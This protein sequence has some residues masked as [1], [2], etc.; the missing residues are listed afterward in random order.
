MAAFRK[1]CHNGLSRLLVASR[2]ARFCQICLSQLFVTRV[3]LSCHPC[4]SQAVSHLLVRSV[5]RKIFHIRLPP[6]LCRLRLLA[7]RHF[8]LSQ[9]MSGLSVIVS[10]AYANQTYSAY[11][12]VA[13]SVCA[14]HRLGR[15]RTSLVN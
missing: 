10:V 7:P 3:H 13:C 12:F 2:D 5:C 14:Q 8:R 9:D 6:R 4:L 11:I 1:L 15:I